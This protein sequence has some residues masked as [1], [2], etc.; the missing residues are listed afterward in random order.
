MSKL[1]A[2]LVAIELGIELNVAVAQNVNSDTNKAQGEQKTMQDKETGATTGDRR[3]QG[4]RD[5][6]ERF[7]PSPAVPLLSFRRR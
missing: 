5:G 4:G 6:S 3:Q 2:A 1:L 7:R